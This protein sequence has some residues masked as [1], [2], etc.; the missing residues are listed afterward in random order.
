MYEE[1]NTMKKLLVVIS[2]LALSQVAWAGNF[3]YSLGYSRGYSQG[4]LGNGNN[5]PPLGE[6]KDDCFPWSI[7]GRVAYT[8]YSFKPIAE[9]LYKRSIYNVSTD[10]AYMRLDPMEITGRI[11]VMK[12]I[13][14]VELIGMVGYTHWE[15]KLQV[16]ERMP[17][18]TIFK[19]AAGANLFDTVSF[20][21]GIAKYISLTESLEWGFEVG[22]EYYPLGW[23]IN[24]C[25]TFEQNKVEPYGAMFVR[26]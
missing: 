1:R 9:V 15:A 26:W 6:A 4:Y 23:K 24:R 20:R 22:G 25:M 19:H 12:E 10:R 5:E 13:Y 8:K 18:G 11:G 7:I 3:D 17:D 21:L 14:G 2:L 16:S